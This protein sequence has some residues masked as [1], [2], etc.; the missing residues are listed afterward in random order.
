MT[1]RPAS[2]VA[3]TAT[4]PSRATV[5]IL[6]DSPLEAAMARKALISQFDVETFSDG[7]ALIE[8]LIAGPEPAALVLDW[9]LPGLSG[10]E[11]CRFVRSLRDEST[12]PILML[13]VYGHK[14]DLVEGLSAGANDYVT[15]PYD[16][17]ELAARISTLVRVKMV[18]ESARR[19]EATVTRLLAGERDARADA[20]AANA[21]KDEFLAMVSHELR[22][23]LNAILGWTRILRAGDFPAA[24]QGR[25]L[26]TVERNALAQ[27]QLIEDLLDM[28][29]IISGKLTIESN[30]VDLVRVVQNAIDAVRPAALTKNLQIDQRIESGVSRVVGDVGRLQQ[31]VWNLLS[32]ALK[33]TASGGRLTVELRQTDGVEIV[34]TD[35][36]AGIDP[37]FLPNVF[38]RFRQGA[39][40]VARS[41][42]GLG[43]GLA[44]VK[45]VIERHGGRVTAAS[46]GLGHGASFTVWLPMAD[47][48]ATPVPVVD[49]T[50]DLDGWHSSTRLRT[51]VILIVDDDLDALDLMRTVLEHHGATVR[52]ASSAAEAFTHLRQPFPDAIVSD[53]GMPIEDGYSFMKRVRA[54][55]PDA[56]GRVPS[57][58]LTAYAHSQ[59]RAMALSCGFDAYV[60]KPVDLEKL[61]AQVESLVKLAHAKPE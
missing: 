58:A 52:S 38:D 40:G 45:Y 53:V 1:V 48:R 49:S 22:T 11:V 37:S 30:Q 59:D 12:L 32:N 57:V 29:R 24:Q 39:N 35:S 61:V 6:E 28:S 19:A 55:P 42:G 46:D 36:G 44:I 8:R 10:I 5:W 25:A 23:P 15:K 50:P 33:F 51:R 43:L 9:Q 2:S 54:L 27:I 31:V 7:S 56:G 20:E 47:G 3:N 21:A 17:P 34:V 16:S 60:S 14:G 13:T 18:H 4:P 41:Y 26:E